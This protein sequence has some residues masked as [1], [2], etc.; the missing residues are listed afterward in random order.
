MMDGDRPEELRP[1]MENNTSGGHGGK[2]ADDICFT[3]CS[4]HTQDCITQNHSIVHDISVYT[5]M[6]YLPCVQFM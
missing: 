5:Q 6:Q 2:G 1:Y 3:V 4:N